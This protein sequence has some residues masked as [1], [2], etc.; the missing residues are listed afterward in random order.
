M[1]MS[2]Y[3]QL[4]DHIPFRHKPQEFFETLK[5]LSESDS[6][7]YF[8]ADRTGLKTVGTTEMIFEKIIG[9]FGGKDHTSQA[10]VEVAL[11]KFLTYGHLQR[12]T[13]HQA[14]QPWLEQLKARTQE[15]HFSTNMTAILD[16]LEKNRGAV[17]AGLKG[18]L[19]GLCAHH[20]DKVDAL[21]GKTKIRDGSHPDFGRTPFILA[22]RALSKGHFD[23]AVQYAESAYI[24]GENYDDVLSLFLRIGDK[25]PH[26]N[27]G[28][29]KRLK[30]FKDY[31]LK[32]GQDERALRFDRILKRI[33]PE[34]P[35]ETNTHTLL[36]LARA[37]ATLGSTQEALGYC[38]QAKHLGVD[39]TDEKRDLYLAQHEKA[40]EKRL[41]VDALN[42][43]LLAIE[44]GAPQDST[45]L[46]DLYL[47][48]AEDLTHAEQAKTG[49]RVERHFG[50]A[51]NYFEKAIDLYK[52]E[53]KML[54][55]LFDGNWLMTYMEALKAEG[56]VERGITTITH[57][58]DSLSE[59]SRESKN[60]HPEIHKLERLEHIRAKKGI[61]M[62]AIRLYEIAMRFDPKNGEHPFKM[63]NLYDY[64]NLE[65][66]TRETFSL[67]M[68]AAECDPTNKYYKIGVI[69][70]GRSQN[71]SI[72]NWC[73][74]GYS[75]LESHLIESWFTSFERFQQGK[76]RPTGRLQPISD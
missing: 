18:H 1:L 36:R 12:Y 59:F 35:P 38:D 10:N 33:E 39:V 49:W 64:L 8:Y 32:N 14:F 9:F 72:P 24:L 67:F 42:Y 11:A 50:Q 76:V 4:P 13:E 60:Y 29:I 61:I 69:V 16:L 34:A 44:C 68:K 7:S 3:E 19:M 48:A 20:G 62:K 65:S 75:G 37:A 73:V 54:D 71:K 23:K 58:A 74:A 57:F 45:K 26:R 63:A 21:G 46:A 6:N 2:N 28:L 53:N 41:P 70:A 30:E 55:K 25:I 31:A 15:L 22:D 5:T 47:K 52:K 43:Y 56:Q 27:D 51:I 66:E 17:K 40:I